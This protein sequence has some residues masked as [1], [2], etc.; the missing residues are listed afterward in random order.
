MT[1][2]F[3][4]SPFKV[5][6]KYSVSAE[7]IPAWE[8][9]SLDNDDGHFGRLPRE[10]VLYIFTFLDFR[11]LVV[12]SQVSSLFRDI[13]WDATLYTR[14]KLRRLFHMVNN[15]TLKFLYNRADALTH[16][17]VSWCGNYGRI[18][19]AVL[20]RSAHLYSIILYSLGFLPAAKRQ[21][22]AEVYTYLLH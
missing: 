9:Y 20:N 17:D 14:V 10:I 1:A 15:Q 18:S 2:L 16:F 21:G 13:S 22:H 5:A 3:Q 7:S 8:R 6:H 4:V 11:S 12:C 19:P